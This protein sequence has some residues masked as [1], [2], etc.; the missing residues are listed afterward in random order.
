MNTGFCATKKTQGKRHLENLVVGGRII[1]KFILN[2]AVGVGEK[3]IYLDQYRENW[4]VHSNA[5]I[6]EDLGSY[7]RAS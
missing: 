1:L 3:W 5:V 4:Q 6:F 7:D 2:K